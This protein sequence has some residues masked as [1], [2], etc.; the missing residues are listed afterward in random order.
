MS[1]YFSE[2]LVVEILKRLPVK[3]LLKFRSVCK[4]WYSLITNLKFI[5]LHIAH[6]IEANK[7]YSLVTKN[8]T[9]Y[10]YPSK[11]QLVLHSDNVSFS[12]HKELDLRSFYIVSAP[13]VEFLFDIVGS[14]NGLVCLSDQRFNRLI[15]WN[16]A[17]GKFITTSL[18]E[19]Y[20]RTVI[21]GFGFDSK[22]IDYKVV[23]ISY[24][25]TNSGAPSKLIQPFVE[26]FELSSSSWK[27]VTV[28]H[29]NYVVRA[30]QYPTYLNGVVHWFAQ[31]YSGISR[32][33]IIA[34]FDLSNEAFEE[35]MLPDALPDQS[36]YI[37]LSLTVYHQKFAI[38]QY[39]QWKLGK[40]NSL[41]FE[42]CCIWVMKEYGVRESWTK[43]LTIDLEN[44]GGSSSVLNFQGNGSILVEERDGSIASYD[45]ET[46]KVTSL[47][48]RGSNFQ[49][50]SYIESLILLEEG[51][52][53]GMNQ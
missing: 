51:K 25:Y 31:I 5:S 33:L 21:V 36:D 16:P 27:T 46:K 10:T 48:V 41:Y 47:G 19:D 12:E 49:V 3:S 7:T 42:K 28:K 40:F 35:L 26:I 24:G 11:Q 14:Y 23:R 15:L 32:K 2:E 22:N 9:P 29:L 45:P 50:Y 30:Y 1:H 39:E 17:I 52:R 34:S 43:Q 13:H 37:N 8:P 20:D 38:I 6:T 4:S 53:N 44:H 18:W